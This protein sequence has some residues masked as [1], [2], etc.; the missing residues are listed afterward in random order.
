M[1]ISNRFVAESAKRAAEAKAAEEER[2]HENCIPDKEEPPPAEPNDEL[3]ETSLNEVCRDAA[4]K[5]DDD[6]TMSRSQLVRQ[7][8]VTS[9]T[10]SADGRMT[11]LERTPS[12]SSGS[13]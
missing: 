7:D 5:H 11:S 10:E 2:G 12:D 3:S 4:E 13:I 9:P 6:K 1:S 8:D